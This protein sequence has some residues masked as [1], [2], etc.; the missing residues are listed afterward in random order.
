MKILPF[1]NTEGV[2]SL[3]EIEFKRFLSFVTKGSY[4]IFKGKLYKEVDR[5]AMSSCLGLTLAY[6]FPVYFE[7]N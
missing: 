3:S 4:C 1:E 6:E 7:K 2:E 5:V